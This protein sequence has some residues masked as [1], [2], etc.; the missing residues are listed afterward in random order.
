M[1]NVDVFCFFT[2]PGQKIPEKYATVS[3]YRSSLFLQFLSFFITLIYIYIYISS[4]LKSN[5]YYYHLLYYVLY[6]KVEG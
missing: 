2:L 4:P 6:S 1:F 5:F 3:T